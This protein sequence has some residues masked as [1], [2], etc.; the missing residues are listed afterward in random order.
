LVALAAACGD[1]STGT[2]SSP[3]GSD[4]ATTTFASSLGVDISAM[5][6]L[7]SS[8]YIQDIAAGTGTAASSSHVLYVTYTGWLANGTQ[9]DSNADTTAFSF[10]LGQG[11]V[12][13]GWDEGLVGIR[14]GGTRRLVV[15]SALGYGTAGSPPRIPSNSTLVFTVK[16]DSL[17]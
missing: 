9:F 10:T 14:V 7:N 17:Q 16:L 12:I 15:G 4:P 2:D 8:L 1:S 11:T 5:T 13:K 6:E 3:P